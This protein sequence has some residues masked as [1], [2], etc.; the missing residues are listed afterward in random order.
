M[1]HSAAYYDNQSNFKQANLNYPP[2]PQLSHP[3]AAH[4]HSNLRTTIAS[5]RT[6]LERSQSSPSSGASSSSASDGDIYLAKNQNQYNYSPRLEEGVAGPRALR[7]SSHGLHTGNMPRAD[8]RTHAE[9][10][11]TN[12]TVLR[13]VESD[14]DDEA[15]GD[16]HALWILVCPPLYSLMLKLTT[17]SG[18]DVLPRSI[19]LH[20][21]RHIFRIRA[22]RTNIHPATAVMSPGMLS[23]Y[24]ICEDGCTRV[25][26]PSPADL[27]Q[28][29][30]RCSHVRV[31][32]VLFGLDPPRV[33][34]HQS[35]KRDC[36]VG[37]GHFLVVC[38]HHGQS[39]RDGKEG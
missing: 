4:L 8:G 37:G 38:P 35:G 16:D 7:H 20:F 22:S 28:I 17:Y 25:S 24:D 33:A 27:R 10:L 13:Y 32:S 29:F 3:P 1:R 9:I 26:Q 21:Q 19:P 18:L 23:E 34:D 5:P 30:E 14:L 15:E 36:R 2:H 6:G 12:S 39:R 31:Q 11:E